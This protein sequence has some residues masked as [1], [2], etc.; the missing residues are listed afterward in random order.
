MRYDVKGIGSNGCIGYAKA[1]ITVSGV[2]QAANVLN[3]SQFE[4]L[5]VFPNPTKDLLNIHSKQ[6]FNILVKD[7]TGKSIGAFK[8]S[9]EKFSIDASH[10]PVGQ[11]ILLLDN[12]KGQS[13][14]I[15]FS[16]E[17]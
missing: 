11:Y 4:D 2:L 7:I 5:V 1:T 16:I 9:S 3:Q 15:K 17:R 8:K 14:S 6:D 12:E 10:F 13:Q